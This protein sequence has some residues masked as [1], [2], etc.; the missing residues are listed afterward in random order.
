[1]R[2]RFITDEA[3]GRS[4]LPLPRWPERLAAALT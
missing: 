3:G 4:G 2:L 1:V